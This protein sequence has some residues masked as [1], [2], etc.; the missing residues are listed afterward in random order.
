MIETTGEGKSAV[1]TPDGKSRK[2]KKVE[3]LSSIRLRLIQYLIGLQ[4]QLSGLFRQD[5]STLTIAGSDYGSYHDYCYI[6]P[7]KL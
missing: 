4:H 2:K 1:P 5:W 3:G 7:N 6:E